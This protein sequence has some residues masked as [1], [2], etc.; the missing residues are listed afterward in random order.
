VLLPQFKMQKQ[1]RRIDPLTKKATYE[2]AEQS[3]SGYRGN[4]KPLVLAAC[5]R[6]GAQPA[7]YLP[8]TDHVQRLVPTFGRAATRLGRYLRCDCGRLGRQGTCCLALRPIV[9]KASS[10]F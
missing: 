1:R 5:P 9:D 7:C 4:G 6:R 3:S 8:I 10:S 2:E